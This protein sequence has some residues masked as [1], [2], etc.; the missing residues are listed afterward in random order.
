MKTEYICPL[1]NFM[2]YLFLIVL[3]IGSL[4]NHS[5][6]NSSLYGYQDAYNKGGASCK[7]NNINHTPP[8]ASFESY[9]EAESETEDDVR[10]NDNQTNCV[11]PLEQN[12]LLPLR[13]SEGISKAK[14]N[15]SFIK[16]VI[17]YSTP[18]YLRHCSFLI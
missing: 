10:D 5:Y 6:G 3:F 2:R 16:A 4:C 17:A 15:Y 9:F 12:H 1:T 13:I 8:F 18:I 11:L 7:Y 14:Y